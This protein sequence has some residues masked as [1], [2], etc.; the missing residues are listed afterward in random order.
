MFPAANFEFGMCDFAVSAF[1]VGENHR[2]FAVF[3]LEV[4]KDAFLFQFAR[5]KIEGRLAILHAVREL[6]IGVLDAVHVEVFETH[7]LEQHLDNLGD[8][9]L[10][11]TPR[12]RNRGVRNHSPEQPRRP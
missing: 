10:L 3:V 12:N 11:L 5:H 6:R 4:I 9:F 8:G 1:L 2:V 7:F